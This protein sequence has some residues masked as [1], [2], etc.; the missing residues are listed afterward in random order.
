VILAS[1]GFEAHLTNS[2][3]RKTKSCV[4]SIRSGPPKVTPLDPTFARIDNHPMHD[5]DSVLAANRAF[6]EAFAKRDVEALSDLLAAETPGA[7]VH[8]GWPPL[9][10][11]ERVLESW[12]GILRGASPLAIT[13]SDATAHLLGDAAYVIC[14]EHL[15][16]GELVAT[17]IFVRENG[18]WKLSHHHA[19]A[20]A[21]STRE[22]D[23]DESS[24]TLH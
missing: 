22:R 1:L 4:Q 16:D 24:G 6:Y 11:R 19:G 8:P 3:K 18:A 13:Y 7:C 10:G 5:E 20:I 15:A 9:L 2:E 23:D 12:R 14:I 17:N 21:F